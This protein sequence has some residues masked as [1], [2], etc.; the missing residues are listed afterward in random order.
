MKICLIILF[1]FSINFIS[2]SNNNPISSNN[3]DLVEIQFDLQTGFVNVSV[4][5]IENGKYYFNA[6]FKGIEPLA[7]PQ[8]SFITY[9]SQGDHYIITRRTPFNYTNI[10]KDTTKIMIGNS[11]KYW[12]G[13]GVYSDSLHVVVQNSAFIYI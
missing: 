1:A 13:M 10:K 12:I 8:A 11:R 7:G 6:F 4:Q 3:H 2:C 5:I 9:L